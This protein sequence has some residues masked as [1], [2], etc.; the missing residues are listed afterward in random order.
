MKTKEILFYYLIFL[1]THS[2]KVLNVHF[3]KSCSLD[4]EEIFPFNN[5]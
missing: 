1:K 4:S 2:W 5:V 3:Y